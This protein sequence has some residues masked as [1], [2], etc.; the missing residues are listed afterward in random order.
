MQYLTPK[1][2]KLNKGA[3]EAE[4]GLF[5]G[6]NNFDPAPLY[7]KAPGETVV[8]N[9]NNAIIVIGHDRPMGFDSGYGGQGFN[10]AS[11]IYLCAGLNGIDP[12]GYFDGSRIE[13]DRNPHKDAAFIHISQMSDVDENLG[14]GM[15]YLGSPDEYIP[16]TA[17]SSIAFK[18]DHLRMVGRE[19]VVIMG[20]GTDSRNSQGGGIMGLAG[21]HLVGN[22]ENEAMLGQQEPLVK[23]EKL[24]NFL[25]ELLSEMQSF[26]D[27]FN[28]FL[29]FQMKFN[30][31]ISSHTHIGFLGVPTAPS[32]RLTLQGIETQIK[33]FDTALDTLKG[34][35]DSQRLSVQFL[36][37]ADIKAGE[38]AQ[39]GLLSDYILSKHNTTN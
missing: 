6:V 2:K 32:L 26:S 9:A 15:T 23:G 21:V 29:N 20:R 30:E 11:D 8:G 12:K 36:G 25:E 28:K 33:S 13:A 17:K 38:Q 37:G 18:A 34:D 24:V 27:T 39:P 5:C 10:A 19:S 16:S 4:A 7:R 22:W 31:A 3:S 14:L 1:Q 35:V